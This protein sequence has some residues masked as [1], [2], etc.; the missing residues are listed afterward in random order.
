VRISVNLTDAVEGLPIW[1]ERFDGTLEDVFELQDTVANAVASQIEPTIENAE[2]RRANTRPTQDLGAYELYL[3]AL[4]LMRMFERPGI[5]EGI[6]LL[7][8]AIRRDPNYALARALM[9][10]I[11]AC[12]LTYGWTEDSES[13]RN[14]IREQVRRALSLAGDD[15]DVLHFVAN[16]SSYAASSA[17]ERASAEAMIDRAL[18]LNPGASMIWIYSAHIRWAMG[19]PAMALEHLRTGLRL[20]P[21][22]PERPFVLAVM[23]GCLVQLGQWAEALPL[24]QEAAQLRAGNPAPLVLLAVAYAKLDRLDEAR[25]ALR[26]AEGMAPARVFINEAFGGP[27]GAEII[28]SGLAL[29]G[30]HV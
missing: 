10:Y 19:R 30:A 8:Q 7:D 29:A 21:R 1:A 23:G 28:R 6:D 11:Q 16:A 5:M 3:R 24:L 13:T 2:T 18:A 22:C 27:Q 20:D 25:A 26:A 4:H 12:V 15:A 17:T 14:I 9:A